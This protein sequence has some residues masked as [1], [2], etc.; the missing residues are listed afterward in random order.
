M[1]N[2]EIAV[3]PLRD[4]RE[5]SLGQK[6]EEGT[7]NK[8]EVTNENEGTTNKADRRAGVREAQASS[9]RPKQKRGVDA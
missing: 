2:T 5:A 3:P 7:T 9:N 1:S 8:D 4:T 6:Q